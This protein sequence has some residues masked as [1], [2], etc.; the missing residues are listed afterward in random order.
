MTPRHARQLDRMATLISYVAVT[1]GMS[2]DVDAEE[3]LLDE[4]RRL[5]DIADPARGVRNADPLTGI[6]VNVEERKRK[7]SQLAMQCCGLDDE[8]A[9][10]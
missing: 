6:A 8:K 1:E 3:S 7:D 2:G 10:G 9:R 4:S 5:H